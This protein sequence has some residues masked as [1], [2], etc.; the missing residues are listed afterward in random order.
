MHG[1]GDGRRGASGLSVTAAVTSEELELVYAELVTSR[2]SATALSP[3]H[4]PPSTPALEACNLFAEAERIATPAASARTR[5]Q[6]GAIFRA[7]GTCSAKS[8][9]CS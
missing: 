4:R 2:A 7:F 8:S 5:R 3:P 9:R 6:Y 1:F